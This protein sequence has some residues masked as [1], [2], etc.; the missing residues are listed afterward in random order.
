MSQEH[1]FETKVRSE[2]S[3]TFIEVPLDVAKLFGKKRAPV[4][5]T[6]DGTPFQSTVAVYGG[7][8]YIPLK[9]ALRDRAGVASGEEV[10]MT[11]A[12]DDRKRRVELPED[13][14]TE[15]EKAGLREHFDRLSYSHQRQHVEAVVEAKKAA[16]RGRRIAKALDM[17][18][19]ELS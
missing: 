8:Y 12:R 13:F 14:A 18:R 1:T 11:L 4:R 3:G 15:L 17:L 5:G 16:T 10:R 2:D 7:R 6:I 19:G 9:R